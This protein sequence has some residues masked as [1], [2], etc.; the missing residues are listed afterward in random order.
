MLKLTQDDMT[1]LDQIDQDIEN[2]TDSGYLLADLIWMRG[3][4]DEALH[5]ID[6]LESEASAI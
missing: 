3:L 6:V 4:L 2:E 1:R 5:T